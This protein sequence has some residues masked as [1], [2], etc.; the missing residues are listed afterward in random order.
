VVILGATN[1][2]IGGGANVANTIAFNGENGVFINA[3]FGI[4]G[5]SGV[6][7]SLTAHFRFPSPDPEATFECSLDGGAYYG[8]SSPENI[9]GPSEGRHV[10]EVRAVDAEGNADPSPAQWIW[11]VDRK[12]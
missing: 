3:A 2:D 9:N 4:S 5:P 6:T 12:R 10:F 1:N 8:C 7:K 11:A